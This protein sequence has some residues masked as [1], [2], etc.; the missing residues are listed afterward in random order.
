MG[1]KNNSRRINFRY[2]VLTIFVYAVG[3]ILLIQLFNLQV[4]H[5]EEYREES[6]TRLTR[7]STL[8]AARGSILDRSGTTLAGTKMGFR[9]DLYRSQVDVNTL[10]NTILNIINILEKNG[11]DYKND[12]PIDTKT[13]K[14]TI[15]NQESLSNWKENNEIPENANE[16]D[17]INYFKK[18]YEIQNEDKAEILKII[19]VRYG[20][21]QDGYSAIRAYTIAEDISRESAIELSEIGSQY[22]GIN[23]VVE[24][25]RNYVNGSFASHVIG[26]IGRITEDEFKEK[27]D[28]Y[29][30]DDYIGRSGIEYVFEEYL[31]GQN[32]IKHIDMDVNGGI[33]EEYIYEEAVAGSDVVLTIDANLQEVA[34]T[35]LKED[36]E[37]IRNGGF[38]EKLDV[39][40]GAV[41]A[42]NVKTGEILALASYPDYEPELFIDGISLEKWNEYNQ[43]GANALF[44]RA[45]Q[46]TYAPG[47]IFK[48]V[49][50]I[51]GL[52]T[53]AITPD[54]QILTR[55]V[56][57]R[58]HKPVCWIYT[59]R[60]TS[61]GLLDVSGAIKN[62]CNYFFYEVGYRMGIE[63]LEKYAKYFGLG[64]KTGI[65]LPSEAT[66]T[67]ATRENLEKTTGETWNLGNTLSAVIGQGQNN[68]TPL[69][70]AKYI[71]ILVNGGNKI[72]PTIVKTIIKPDGTEVPK[73]EIDKFVQEKLGTTEE[74][75][76]EM[77]FKK[78]NIQAI[79]EGMKSVTSETGGTAYGTFQDFEIEVGGKTGSAEAG[80]KVNAWFAGFAPYDN[81][82]IAIVV[83]VEGGSTG[84][85]T[86]QVAK[87][88]IQE[89][90]GENA[91]DIEENITAQPYTES[92]AR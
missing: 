20:I 30:N 92:V 16:D 57:P 15:E 74:T 9:L 61:H 24:P 67:L 79:L 8:E 53:G 83:L 32:G 65:E 52:E 51:A 66:G 55:G 86:A 40:S 26:Y 4:I 6:N 28:T 13:Y 84:G 82:E 34:E 38:G 27:K 77:T 36:I 63:T 58:A 49:T 2:N 68:F 89:Y 47:S 46:G 91:E 88:I 23:I 90:F 18:E 33:T 69:Q 75:Q 73:E 56:Y 80:N 62:S 35:A 12:F 21:S 48:M 39:K 59:D 70:I 19:S 76:E 22:S 3:I 60:H 37:K 71:S 25:I 31:K 11:D 42:M 1:E 81:P 45:I 43:E 29:R 87:A 64:S 72:N 5:G 44:N 50:A 54:E 78:E 14:F 17:V 85:Y 10:N 41:V 7:E